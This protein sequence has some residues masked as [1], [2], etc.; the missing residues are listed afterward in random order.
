M[1]A[2]LGYL[3]NFLVKNMMILPFPQVSNVKIQEIQ[4]NSEK[5]RKPVIPIGKYVSP[6]GQPDDRFKKKTISGNIELVSINMGS[7][8][9]RSGI[10][11]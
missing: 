2:Q 4:E 6:I 5:I 7:P 10:N 9:N 8:R 11:F 3:D 1:F